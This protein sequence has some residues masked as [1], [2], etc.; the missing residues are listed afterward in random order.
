MRDGNDL[1][2]IQKRLRLKDAEVCVEAGVSIG[3]LRRIY[4]N[5][6]TVTQES[7]NKV[8]TALERLRHRLMASLNAKAVS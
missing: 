7:V 4:S 8:L 5:E 2:A 1:K 6:P 3:T